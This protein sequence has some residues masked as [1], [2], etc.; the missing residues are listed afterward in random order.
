[1]NSPEIDSKLKAQ[2]LQEQ[3]QLVPPGFGLTYGAKYTGVH[4]AGAGHVWAKF[5][6]FFF[7]DKP[8]F[9]RFGGISIQVCLLHGYSSEPN[10]R[11]LCSSSF[12]P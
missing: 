6:L 7:E 12:S 1:M 4:R 11:Q 10:A 9:I 8:V 5:S 2:Q 3:A